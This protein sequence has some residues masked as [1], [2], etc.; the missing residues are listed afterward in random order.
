MSHVIEID[1]ATNDSSA[2]KETA[3]H[4]PQKIN[5]D[6]KH[7]ML[8]NA[9]VPDKVTD[10]FNDADFFKLHAAPSDLYIQLLNSKQEVCAKLAFFEANNDRHYISPKRGT[11]GGLSLSTTLELPVLETFVA[12]VI[13]LLK[14]RQA[15][16]V[17][18]KLAPFSHDAALSALMTNILLRNGFQLNNHELNYD[19][20]VNTEPLSSRVSTGNRKRIKKCLNEGFVSQYHPLADIAQIY[21]VIKVNRARR[22]FPLTMT[23]EQ[24]QTMLA[25]FPDRYHLFSVHD[26]DNQ[27]ALMIASAICI[28]VS[29]SVL[30]V[31]YW[32]DIAGYE[33]YSPITLL[34]SH[35]YAFC[36]ENEFTLLDVGTSSL[37]G[38]PSYGIAQFKRNLGFSES[39]KPDFRLDFNA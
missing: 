20:V 36:Q 25:L 9:F 2:H 27:D 30:Y 16:S 5:I 24:V 1:F 12:E 23:L 18:I 21:E 19:M 26:S 17:T 7:H 29:A 31:F 11:F 15:K 38:E 33:R 34:A 28:A 39:L 8:I 6:D 4:T 22:G 14:V 37:S 13:Q 32:G 3:L 10:L 35:I